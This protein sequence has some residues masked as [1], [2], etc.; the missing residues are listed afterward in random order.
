MA[1]RPLTPPVPA[2]VLLIWR[3]LF[4]MNCAYEFYLLWQCVTIFTDIGNQKSL[5]K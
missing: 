3:M 5:E 2:T 1:P 4:M